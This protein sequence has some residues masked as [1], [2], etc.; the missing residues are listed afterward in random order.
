MLN[1]NLSRQSLSALTSIYDMPVAVLG[2]LWRSLHHIVSYSKGCVLD[3]DKF[4]LYSASPNKR[5]YLPKNVCPFWRSFQHITQF[6]SQIA[7][8]LE[9][10]EEWGR[11]IDFFDR[12]FD[13]TLIY[14]LSYFVISVPLCNIW[15]TF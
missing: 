1:I 11:T 7:S 3:E 5:M 15:P 2:H 6:Y 10:W 13:V 12:I 14:M 9:K 8:L 4:I